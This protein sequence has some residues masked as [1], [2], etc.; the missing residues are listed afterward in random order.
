VT[1]Y[2]TQPIRIHTYIHTHSLSTSTK[3]YQYTTYISG[4]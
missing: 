3:C 4:F 1:L 2:M